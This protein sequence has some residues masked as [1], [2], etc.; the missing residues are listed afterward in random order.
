M[1]RPFFFLFLACTTSSLLTLKY[2]VYSIDF[3]ELRFSRAMI[4]ALEEINNNTKML[5]GIKL[6]YQIHD[7]CT[8][9]PVA[10]YV[11]FQLLNGPEPA[12]YDKGDCSKAGTVVAI[13]GES[14]STPSISMSCI[15]GFFDIPLV[16]TLH[17]H[18]LHR[19]HLVIPE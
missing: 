15:I 6:G 12:H 19:L 5:P 17:N 2:S 9:V 18:T 16:N 10:V 8:S 3:C 4:F 1:L 7:S 13:V 14:G 11:A